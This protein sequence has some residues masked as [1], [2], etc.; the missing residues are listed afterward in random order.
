MEN[1]Q[2]DLARKIIETTDT[3]LFLT[4][5]AGTGKTTFL[6]QLR[7]E[8]PKRMVVLAPTGIAAINAQGS[9]IHSFFQLSFA[10]YVP[11]MSVQ[12]QRSYKMNKEKIKLIQSLDLLVI[13]EISMV[14][15]DLLDAVDDAL[16]R[17]RHSTQPFGGVQLLLI[18]DLQQLTPV[19]KDEEW[20]LLS[21]YYATPYFFSSQALNQ[22]DYVTVELEKIYRQSDTHFLTLLNG[23]RE[24]KATD[25][26]LSEL[27]KRYIPNFAPHK[28]EGYIRL[29]THN[30]QAQQINS[31]E[32][33]QLNT[34]AFTYEAQIT[35]R[36]S[37]QAYPT[38]PFLTLKQ[39]AQVM[40]VKNDVNKTYF[41]GMIGEVVEINDHGFSVRPNTAPD[42]I[43]YVQ[44]EEWQNTRFALDPQ[45]KEIKEEVEGTFTQ[46]PVK[47]AWAITIHKSQGLTFERVMIDASGAFA[48]GQTYVAL[49]RCKTLEGIVLTTPIP[50]SAIIADKNLDAFTT[51]MQQ[52]AVS[53][54]KLSHMRK[55][56]SA[57]LLTQLFTF[58]RERILLSSYTRLLQEHLTSL[59]AQT[60]RSFEAQLRKFDLSVMNVSSRFHQQYATLLAANEGNLT[61]AHLQERIQ[62]GANYFT[63]CLCEVSDLLQATH[64][65][66][67]NA[68]LSQRVNATQADAIAQFKL[69]IKLLDAVSDEGFS[70][71]HFLHTRARLLL[72]AADAATPKK[73]KARTTRTPRTEHAKFTVPDEVTNPTLYYRLKEWRLKRATEQHL[74]PYTVLNTK[75]MMTLANFAPTHTDQLKK[76]PYL[77]ARSIERYGADILQVIDQYL[78]DKRNGHIEEQSAEPVKQIVR[79]GE[80]TFDA[81]LR[82]FKEDHM[83]IDQIAQLRELTP[84]TIMSHLSRFLPT[85]QVDINDIVTPEAYNRIKAYFSQTDYQLN[86]PLSEVRTTIGDDLSYGEIRLVMDHLGVKRAQ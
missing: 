4:G 19:V 54:T 28:D 1:Q 21:H 8:S 37:D 25:Q 56:Y 40:F 6:R 16:R 50:P 17:Y 86:C 45:T 12:E 32:L 30:W 84:S 67:D 80:S 49:S 26:L 44:P 48:H 73:G 43:I 11:G 81:T 9:T 24:A 18:G 42:K 74:P 77:G 20:A 63:N 41:N 65:D 46:Y 83:T 22:T 70:V 7:D 59:Y 15:A 34:P 68:Q 64:L 72:E 85:G 29:V 58:E 35:G 55:A 52:R 53:P 3:N 38:D 82:L 33:E 57:H 51:E 10:P 27:N 76:V 23:V 39:G 31:H 79:P 62:K 36:F 2:K 47:L 66:I 78:A 13:D 60:A 61:D 71:S 5:R 14:R 69:H 75:A